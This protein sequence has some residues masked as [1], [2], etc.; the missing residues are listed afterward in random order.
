MRLSRGKR[1]I[2]LALAVLVAACSSSA[3]TPTPA[4]VAP[5]PAPQATVAPAV[6]PAPTPAPATCTTLTVWAMPGSF[7][8]ST[9][10]Q[11]IT[12][13]ENAH[14]GCVVNYQ[15]QQWNGIVAKLTTALASNNPPDVFEIGNTDAITFE[16]AGALADLTSSRA[17]LGGGTSNVSADPGQL[18]LAS[19]NDASVL[20][21]K[22]YAVPFYAGDRVLIYRTDLFKAANIDPTTIT[23][24]AK[25]IAAAQTLQTANKSV[26]DFSGLYLPGQNWYALMQMIW[27][28]GGQ[29]ATQGSDGKWAGALETPASQKGIQD[30]VDYYK[31]GS[32]GPM[33]N[34]EANPPQYTLFAQGKIGMMICNGWEIGLS[35]GANGVVKTASQIGVL[36]IP[37]VND[38]K[39]APVFLGGSVI[40]IA[41]NSKNVPAAL[42][43]V[44]QLSQPQ[45]ENNMIGDGWIPNLKQFAANIPDTP[46]NATLKVQASEAAAGSGFTPNAVGWAAVEANNPIKAMMTA[47]LTGQMT[48]DQAAKDADSKINA[49]ING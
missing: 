32:T 27:D 16:A 11:L 45:A 30:Y 43:F 3:A 14:P 42:D 20:N 6:T 46:A 5:T 17:M 4:S 28:N 39:T 19:L 34:D 49:V 44:A 40:G 13:F 33:N 9:S 31:A 22:L 35:I 26:K 7:S 1:L 37:S 18:W 10:N 29:I 38:G 21:G 25:L 36:P 12:S 48:V 23:S 15:V 2:P 47:I 24:K 8:S 41:K